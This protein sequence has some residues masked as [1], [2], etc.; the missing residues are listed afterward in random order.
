[1]FMI[2][3]YRELLLRRDMDRFWD[4]SAFEQEL[5]VTFLPSVLEDHKAP[6]AYGEIAWT[7]KSAT[8]LPRTIRLKGR[9][10]LTY[11]GSPFMRFPL[12]TYHE[13]HWLQHARYTSGIPRAFLVGEDLFLIGEVV[14][15]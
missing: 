5:R 3:Y 9:E 15:D 8:P 7:F 2:G 1:K 11:V 14:P 10:G 4:P 13:A 12:T 6:S